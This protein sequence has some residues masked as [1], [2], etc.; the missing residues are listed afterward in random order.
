MKV[1]MKKDFL[2]H[3]AEAAGNRPA[4]SVARYGLIGTLFH[5]IFSAPSRS[6]PLSIS[7]IRSH[8]ENV[9]T[10]I[11]ACDHL[12]GPLITSCYIVSIVGIITSFSICITGNIGTFQFQFY[13]LPL[14]V[15]LT[16]RYNAVTR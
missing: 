10:C 15:H 6:S 8:A 11:T 12:K 9:M 4:R 16:E 14:Q 3:T 1:W 5:S 7:K 2:S 13:V